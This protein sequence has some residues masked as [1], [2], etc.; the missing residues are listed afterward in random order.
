MCANLEFG[1]NM[2]VWREEHELKEYKQ[3]LS[4]DEGMEIDFRAAQFEKALTPI[5]EGCEP[6]SNVSAER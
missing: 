6:D 2:T 4:T 1:S 3:T 5:S